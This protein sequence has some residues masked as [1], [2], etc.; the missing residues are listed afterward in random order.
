MA[1]GFSTRMRTALLVLTGFLLQGAPLAAQTPGDSI[2]CGWD[3][4]D[5]GSDGVPTVVTTIVQ[6]ASPPAIIPSETVARTTGWVHRCSESD[7]ARATW[8]LRRAIERN[9]KEPALRMLRA[10]LLAHGPEVQ[11]TGTTGR[12]L[13]STHKLSN[14]EKEATRLLLAAAKETQWPE[15]ALELASLT[16][17]TRR[18]SG[19]KDALAAVDAAQRAHPENTA[20]SVAR[21]ELLLARGDLNAAYEAA[22]TGV[23]GGDPRAVRLRGI[24]MMRRDKKPDAGAREYL[25]AL[26]AADQGGLLDYYEDLVLLFTDDELEVWRKLPADERKAWLKQSWEW[27]AS[28]ATISVADR[29]AEHFRRLHLS[30]EE[31]TR[32]AFRGARPLSALWL[33]NSLQ[34]MPL[35]DRGLAYVRHGPPDDIVRASGQGLMLQAWYYRALDGGR[36]LL[37]FDKNDSTGRVK[38]GDYFLVEPFRCGD[39]MRTQETRIS[40]NMAQMNSALGLYRDRVNALDA[41]IRAD[42]GCGATIAGDS[43]GYI[44]RLVTAYARRTIGRAVMKTETATPR[45]TRPVDVIL[46]TYAFRRNAAPVV[47]VHAFA[48]V[49]TL[50]YDT[51]SGGFAYGI[52]LFA[53]AENNITRTLSRMDTIITLVRGQPYGPTGYVGLTMKLNATSTDDGTIRVGLRNVRD[54]AQGQV[55]SVGREIPA[56]ATGFALSDA[57]IGDTR[58][59]NW[60]DGRAAPAPLADH[61]TTVG[62]MF[63]VFYEAYGLNDAEPLTVEIS[64]LPEPRRGLAGSIAE[65]LQKREASTATFT[66]RADLDSDAVLRSTRQIAADMPPGAYFVEVKV[67]RA[68]G[69]SQTTRTHMSIHKPN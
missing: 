18:E 64:L 17:G 31:Y 11:V 14:S 67:T 36:A 5:L 34:K 49:G 68:N 9:P 16:I 51:T 24:I 20:L 53:A 10:V 46:N 50:T 55:V 22:S 2:K 62:N 23:D 13:R 58:S 8:E 65:M 56:F 26:E 66:E 43:G 63:S 42:V 61:R 60:L 19:M 57:V 29:L 3:Q 15:A 35:D 12:M 44:P 1:P 41:S 30:F 48:R 39:G 59:T 40:Q 25:A 69:Q 28:I 45:M 33:D 38:W 32:T 21:A 27:R 54:T 37:E 6:R 47:Y 4:R 7:H 52:K